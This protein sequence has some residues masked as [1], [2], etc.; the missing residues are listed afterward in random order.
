MST[1]LFAY[2]PSAALYRA[3]SWTASECRFVVF[4]ANVVGVREPLASFPTARAA[5]QWCDKMEAPNAGFVF[6]RV[7]KVVICVEGSAGEQHPGARPYTEQSAA[8]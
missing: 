7:A 2:C 8:A 4:P 3:L 6:D 1:R 5:L